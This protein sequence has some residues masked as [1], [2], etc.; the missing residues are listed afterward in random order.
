MQNLLEQVHPVASGQILIQRNQIDGLFVE[1]LHG[2]AGILGSPDYEE[3]TE[4]ESERIARPGLVIDD[5]NGRLLLYWSGTGDWIEVITSA[6]R[7]DRG[8]SPN[9]HA[10]NPLSRGVFL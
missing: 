6:S 1:N 2:S 5:E 8:A 9:A 3:W 4:D 10:H 7:R